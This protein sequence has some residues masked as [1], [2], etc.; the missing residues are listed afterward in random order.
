MLVDHAAVVKKKRGNIDRIGMSE[1]GG[2]D[3][4]LGSLLNKLADLCIS[5]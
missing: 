1:R 4:T 5:K 3:G 2:V